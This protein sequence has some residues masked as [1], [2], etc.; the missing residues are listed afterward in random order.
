MFPAYFASVSALAFLFTLMS[1]TK[2][3][4]NALSCLFDT[5]AQDQESSASPRTNESS[6]VD[7]WLRLHNHARSLGGVG[8]FLFRISRVVSCL[9]LLV[10]AALSL[11]LEKQDNSDVL[12]A[13]NSYS[14]HRII[15]YNAGSRSSFTS[16]EWLR[17]AMCLTYVIVNPG[18]VNSMV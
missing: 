3:V 5:K 1:S 18:F 9:T 8:I 16:E 11:V 17:M 13:S 14:Q 10:F 15:R 6:S 7:L 4:R 2:P 12:S